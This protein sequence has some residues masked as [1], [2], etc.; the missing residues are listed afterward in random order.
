MLAVLSTLGIAGAQAQSAKQKPVDKA[1][2]E[3]AA[4]RK[5]ETPAAVT[6]PVAQ[7]GAN[8]RK[9]GR[10]VERPVRAHVAPSR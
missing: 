6:A 8:A 2:A 9:E 10:P 1:K 3:R 5:K 4:D 7:D